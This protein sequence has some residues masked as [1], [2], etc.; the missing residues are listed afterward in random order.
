VSS[1]QQPANSI[2][3]AI[4]ENAPDTRTAFEE[5]D[6]SSLA[7]TPPQ[8]LLD[9][10]ATVES[11]GSAEAPRR[12]WPG[13]KYWQS[14]LHSLEQRPW[15]LPLLVSGGIG[16]IAV[17]SILNLPAA[18]N[19]KS[20]PLTASDSERL[21]CANQA[22]RQGDLPELL[23]ALKMISKWP[24]SHPLH[25]QANSLVQEW[26]NSI[27][28]AARQKLN[29]GDLKGATELARSIPASTTAY[30]DAQAFITN[31]DADVKQGKGL[32]E[33]VQVSIKNQ[34][35]QQATDQ[36]KTLG[37]LGSEY[38]QGQARKLLE[39][40]AAEKLAWGQLQDA[41]AIADSSSADRLIRA[42]EL[43]SKVPSKTYA[44]ADAKQALEEWSQDLLAIAEEKQTAGDFAGALALVE[45]IAPGS[46]AAANSKDLELIGKAQTAARQDTFMGYLE[47]WAMAE[48]IPVNTPLRNRAES[49]VKTWQGQMQNLAQI[50]L[51]Q[52]LASSNQQLGYQ[53]AI[54]Q[55]A[56]IAQ[57]QPRRE[58]A[59]SLVQTWQQQ[60]TRLKDQPLLVAAVSLAEQKQVEAALQVAKRISDQ[61]LYDQAIQEI[62]P[63]QAEAEVGADRPILE[64]ARDLASQGQLTAAIAMAAK[65]EP[66]RALYQEA[67]A[68][69]ADWLEERDGPKVPTPAET[70]TPEPTETP[71][72]EATEPEVIAPEPEPTPYS[73]PSSL[74]PEPVAP[75]SPS[76]EGVS[77]SSP[78]PTE[79]AFGLPSPSEP[80]PS[81]TATGPRGGA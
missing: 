71:S 11:A 2:P 34:D 81:P 52:T 75:S 29:Q 6:S 10:E 67:Q 64:R 17:F 23:K 32:D 28:V 74:S 5:N 55:A 1:D 68:A 13:A 54:D 30:A 59:T 15:T 66:G 56:V 27:L 63:W 24:K 78:T 49:Q 48:Q 80:E 58:Q 14:S 72:P 37:Q 4:P 26:S 31:L 9:P 50:G 46:S 77:P 40:I 73:P 3:P 70:T 22:G 43:A 16:A 33:Q 7:Q 45:K 51:A 21:Y 69:I 39:Q 61:G 65:I 47:A 36:A 44:F 19:C 79:P 57:D 42:I 12:S 38:W 35:W 62:R 25:G 18:T 60:V 20:L 41:E 53:L 8:T 76:P